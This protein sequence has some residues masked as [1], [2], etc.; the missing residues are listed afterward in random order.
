MLRKLGT[1]SASDIA[2]M[3]RSERAAAP[4]KNKKKRLGLF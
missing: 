2:A 4:Q 3:I 1:A